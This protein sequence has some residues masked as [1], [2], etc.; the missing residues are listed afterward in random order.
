MSGCPMLSAIVPRLEF[1]M[2]WLRI[3]L[4]SSSALFPVELEKYFVRRL[5]RNK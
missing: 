3:L 5:D 2:F 4:V 1:E